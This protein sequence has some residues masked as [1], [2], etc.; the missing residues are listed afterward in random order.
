[1]LFRK[2]FSGILTFLLVSIT[3]SAHVNSIGN[4]TDPGSVKSY[5]ADSR[6]ME[7]VGHLPT[8]YCKSVEVKGKKIYITY[9]KKFEII[10]FS[11]SFS[12]ETLGE[13]D[14]P[15]PARGMAV[16]GNSAYLANDRAGLI[17]IDISDPSNPSEVGYYP[18]PTAYDVDVSGKYAYVACKERGEYGLGIIDVSDPEAPAEVGSCGISYDVRSIRVVGKYAYLAGVGRTLRIIDVSDPENPF[19][20]GYYK[21]YSSPARAEGIAISGKYAFTAEFYDGG[22]RVIDISNPENPFMVGYLGYYNWPWAYDVAV[23]G[24]YAYFAHG[25]AGFKTI[26]ISNPADPV[27]AGMYSIH[28]HSCNIALSGKYAY[29]ANGS[30]GLKIFDISKPGSLSLSG[31][32]G[33]GDQPRKVVTSGNFAYIA[34]WRQGL[35]IVDISDPSKPAKASFV[36][37]GYKTLDVAIQENYAYL[38]VEIGL[39]VID[40]SDPYNPFKVALCWHNNLYDA[41]TVSISGDYAYLGNLEDGFIIYDVSDPSNPVEVSHPYS[42]GSVWDIAIADNYAYVADG[43]SCLTVFDISNRSDPFIAGRYN[44]WGIDCAYEV[45]LS[46]KYAYIAT[47]STGLWVFDISDPSDPDVAGYF[48]TPGNATDVA[49]RDGLAYMACGSAGVRVIDISDYSSLRETGFYDTPDKAYG[50]AV[51]NDYIYVANLNEGFYILDYSPAV[52]VLFTNFTA[53]PLD[54][55]SIELQWKMGKGKYDLK[56]FRI[57]RSTRTESPELICGRILDPYAER[58]LDRGVNKGEKYHYVIE[59]VAN[60]G[61]TVHSQEITAHPIPLALELH[62]NFPNPFNPSTRISFTLPEPGP[63]RLEIFDIN[64]R[65][66]RTLIDGHVGKGLREANWNGRDNSG[67]AVAS[68]LYF[69]RLTAG[70]EKITRKAVLIK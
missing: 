16:S 10:R 38:A 67:R 48:D 49:V 4:Y 12:P 60:D 20:T 57:L 15:M 26:D 21:N 51:D 65:L 23:R 28:G 52:S 55:G 7:L 35:M 53:R 54:D 37:T 42:Y 27:E 34:D 41:V 47:G 59:A 9:G 69:Y 17:I 64:G 63:V 22:M 66:V 68:G 3:L 50:I 44:P 30:G 56:G 61:S 70:K 25:F 58:Y 40:I 24:N 6:N 11:P 14:L 5:I 18:T 13:T 2:L 33:T 45:T 19:E 43:H 39:R 31:S 29:L 1:M 32:Y 62:P 36:D 8:G 46:G